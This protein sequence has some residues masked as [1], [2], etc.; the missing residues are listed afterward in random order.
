M[1]RWVPYLAAVSARSASAFASFSSVL[2]FGSWT[3]KRDAVRV[4]SCLSRVLFAKFCAILITFRSFLSTFFCLSLYNR[5]SACLQ[6]DCKDISMSRTVSRLGRVTVPASVSAG[7][8]VR[9]VDMSFFVLPY[10]T[11]QLWQHAT[12]NF[13]HF[14]I[15]T[16]KPPFLADFVP[17]G[18]KFFCFGALIGGPWSLILA[19]FRHCAPGWVVLCCSV[20]ALPAAFPRWR[21]VCLMLRAAFFF[22]MAFAWAFLVSSA[23][24]VALCGAFSFCFSGN[25]PFRFVWWRHAFMQ[26]IK[27]SWQDLDYALFWFW[28]FLFLWVFWVNFRPIVVPWALLRPGLQRFNFAPFRGSAAPLVVLTG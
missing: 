23:S 28:I 7:N 16:Q 5:Q 1:P 21:V 24:C 27:K 13:F 12:L 14:T 8:I 26:N 9:A 22:C 3:N 15:P 25:C 17:I 10:C 2:V 4:P 20:V 18:E 19:C 11:A 6:F